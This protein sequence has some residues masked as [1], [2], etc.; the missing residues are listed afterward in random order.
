MLPQ[1]FA[2]AVC[3]IMKGLISV[4]FGIV[5]PYEIGFA[6]GSSPATRFGP[7]L[8]DVKMGIR[9]QSA[10]CIVDCAERFL[11]LS[12]SNVSIALTQSAAARYPASTSL[13]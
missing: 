11:F 10:E 4:A 8:T 13:G 9:C 1:P 5:N 2:R 6:N 7:P 12:R 3:T